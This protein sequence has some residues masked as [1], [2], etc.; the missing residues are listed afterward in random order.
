MILGIYFI[1]VFIG[2]SF[3]LFFIYKIRKVR[4]GV[5]AKILD[6]LEG[7]GAVHFRKLSRALNVNKS[8]LRH[9]LTILERFNLVNSK[10]SGNFRV[11]YIDSEVDNPYITGTEGVILEHIKNNPGRKEKEIAECFKLS[12]P[13]VSYHLKRL[14]G[15][16][17]IQI[18]GGGRGVRLK[19]GGE[20]N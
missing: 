17:L 18:E 9:H 16:G 13:T 10:K 14:E 4:T 20:K 7:Y 19:A 15:K 12:I 1:L 5:R 3:L 8:T 11:Y 2:L 6:Y